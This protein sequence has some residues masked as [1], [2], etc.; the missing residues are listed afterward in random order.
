[1]RY[2]PGIT[3]DQPSVSFEDTESTYPTSGQEWQPQPMVSETALFHAWSME[4]DTQSEK[5]DFLKR[6]A[7]LIRAIKKAPPM[8]NIDLVDQY[9]ANL[10][11]DDIKMSLEHDMPKRAQQQSLNLYRLYAESRGI[12]GFGSK[13]MVT[14]HNIFEEKKEVEKEK[15]RGFWLRK[16]KQQQAQPPPMYPQ[17]RYG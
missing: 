11:W 8:A 6:H 12:G 3:I 9:K 7:N 10:I 15:K 13:I 5:A 2:Q 16:P 4:L 1:M 17:E 14:Q